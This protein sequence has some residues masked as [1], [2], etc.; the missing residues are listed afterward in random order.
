MTG[1][2][3]CHLVRQKSLKGSQKINEPP[4]ELH[5]MSVMLA[6]SQNSSLV[7]K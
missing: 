1:P 2:L 5:H 4:R 6:Y 3:L 7:L